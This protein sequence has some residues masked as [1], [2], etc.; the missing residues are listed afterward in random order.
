M[1]KCFCIF[2]DFLT[3]LRSVRLRLGTVSPNAGDFSSL[4]KPQC[5]VCGVVRCGVWCQACGAP[6]P[7]Q[8]GVRFSS[9][10]KDNDRSTQRILR[11]LDTKSVF[12]DAAPVPHQKNFL[13]FSFFRFLAPFLFFF[14]CLFFFSS[15]SL[16]FSPARCKRMIQWI[17][18][19][20]DA[21][22]PSPHTPPTSRPI[23]LPRALRGRAGVS[24]PSGR[25]GKTFHTAR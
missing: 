14:E 10:Q 18:A 12:T 1:K 11:F 17:L 8:G 21:S 7:V 3:F 2:D 19:P 6:S 24:N 9:G 4:W 25:G 16:W 5:K 13:F 23:A 22:K 15:P 20:K